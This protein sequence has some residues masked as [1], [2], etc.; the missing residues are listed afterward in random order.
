MPRPQDLN[1][2]ASG[3]IATQNARLAEQVQAMNE[4]QE[5]FNALVGVGCMLASELANN[6][7][8]SVDD[9]GPAEVQFVQMLSDTLILNGEP[10]DPYELGDELLSRLKEQP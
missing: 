10:L 1:I 3:A 2:A 4:L 8:R 5:T 9:I 7:S 6:P